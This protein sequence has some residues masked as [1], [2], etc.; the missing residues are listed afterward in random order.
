MFLNDDKRAEVDVK[1]N[2]PTDA[3]AEILFFGSI[4]PSTIR[5]V[6]VPKLLPEKDRE[7]LIN[8]ENNY[9]GIKFD[10]FCNCGYFVKWSERSRK[11]D[12]TW[13]PDGI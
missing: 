3:Q 12:L 13:E 11:W 10:S 1:I 5:E 8:L 4:F 6:H 2:E 9:P 7:F